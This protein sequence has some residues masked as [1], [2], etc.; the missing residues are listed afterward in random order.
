MKKLTIAVIAV[1]A[2]FAITV[3]AFAAAYTNYVGSATAGVA[4]RGPAVDYFKSTI[5]FAATPSATNDTFAVLGIPSNAVMLA[6]AYSV[7]TTNNAGYGAAT[8]DIG[9]A[10][11]ATR[12]TSAGTMETFGSAAGSASAYCYNYNASQNLKV[13]TYGVMSNGTLTVYGAFIRPP[14][15]MG[16]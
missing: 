4:Y 6:V 8:F 11:S 13:K 1:L 14:Q 7:D 16:K 2:A 9:D 3:P 12:Y 15:L 5:N 10:G